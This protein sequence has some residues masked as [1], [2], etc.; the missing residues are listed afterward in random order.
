MLDAQLVE[1]AT[2]KFCA[3]TSDEYKTCLDWSREVDKYPFFE[4]RLG[5]IQAFD[6]DE[7]MKQIENGKADF[8]LLDPGEVYIAGRYHSVVPIMYEQ[9]APNNQSG[10]YAVAVVK[11]SSFDYIRNLQDLRNKKA[12][13]S[14]VGHLAGWVLPINRLLDLDLID[15]I[16][17]NNIVNN[18][19][20]FFDSSCAPNA[21]L[22]KY[23]PI[24]TNP[25]SMCSLCATSKCAGN[26]RYANHD[27]AM[28]CLAHHGDVAFVKHSVLDQ[29]I[30]AGKILGQ[31][32]ELLCPNGGRSAINNYLQCNWGHSPSNAI[33]ISSTVRPNEREVIQRFITRLFGH[34][35][36]GVRME[37]TR[38]NL[39]Q[40]NANTS[41][42]LI[43]ST[44][45][46]NLVPVGPY[47]QTFRGYFGMFEPR[48]DIQQLFQQMRKCYVPTAKLCV[49]S[50]QEMEK[51]NRMKTAFRTQMLKPD[52]SCVKAGS[53]R[54]CMRNIQQDLADITVL[55]AADIYT[56]GQR[57]GLEPILA[58]QNN[59]NDSYYVVAIAKKSD[60]HTDLL[61]LK[62]KR[63]CHAGYK[64]AAG[65]VIPMAFLLSNSR[66]RNHG[67]N[68]L[69]SASEFF[70]KSCVPGALSPEYSDHAANL[71]EYD[72]L[73]QLCHGNSYRF[74]LRDSAEPYF[75]DTGAFRCL[76]EGGGN[77]AFAKHTAIFENTNGRNP[78][79]WSRNKIDDDF[80]LLCKDGS[81]NE[82]KNFAECNLG[83]VASNAIVTSQY[84]AYL[85]KEAYM[86][87]FIYAQQFYGSKYSKYFT[88]KMF[89]SDKGFKDLIFQDSTVNLKLIAPEKRDYR[90]YLGHEF[91]KA[92]S[93]VDCTAGG[94]G[95]SSNYSLLIVTTI[96]TF[97]YF[98]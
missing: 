15:I 95:L 97:L 57:Y 47:F 37:N 10:Y 77:I 60:P 53:T 14:G 68:S 87:L 78:A 50:D 38:Y 23:N 76:V 66:M 69:K 42:D 6:K 45:A 27:G 58:E 72:N 28:L 70:S 83:Q 26:D 4:Y 13:F 71:W 75:G 31:S 41:M 32:Y 86:N 35:K 49:I 64:T 74:C 63:S 36:S 81:R 91:L 88:F 7:C 9:Y 94:T 48:L 52:L 79:F 44:D 93:V 73:C 12:C 8:V 54:E 25:Q 84:K 20:K 59:L 96:L 16:D 33:V 55:D 92:M 2:L 22:E 43:F 19:A 5:C 89:V 40:K 90:K 65:W 24:G 18:T 21:L 62:G 85:H 1:W 46:T 82:V 80:E 98:H 67:C 39:F 11:A 61:F 17:C 56:A 51:C 30:K 29:M 3:I 34:L